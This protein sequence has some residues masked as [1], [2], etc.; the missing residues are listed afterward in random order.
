MQLRRMVCELG[1][2]SIS[3]FFPIL[4]IQQ[5]LD[6]AGN[7]LDAAIERRF[8]RFASELG[9]VCDGARDSRAKQGSALAR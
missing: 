6:D 1:M 5:A 3:S 2:P 8:T 9:V 4:N 7:P